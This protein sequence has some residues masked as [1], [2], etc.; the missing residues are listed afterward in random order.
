[1]TTEALL[2][3]LNAGRILE[4]GT[5]ESMGM[6]DISVRAREICALINQGSSDVPRI[7]ELFS[8]LIGEPVPE[9]FRLFPPFTS[10]FGRNI[11]LGEN[12]FINSGC[13][14]QDQGGVWIGSGSLIGHNVVIATLNHDLDPN[15]RQAMYSKPVVLGE[16]VWVGAGAIIL[17]GIT[18]GDGAV[19]GAGSIVTRNVEAC[20]IVAGNPARHIRHVAETP[21]DAALKTVNGGS[22]ETAQSS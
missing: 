12:V 1:M 2:D 7:G 8:E 14:F 16:N 3:L 18:V 9:G 20:S 15:N 11:H 4:P 5:P 10:D 13:R 22:A 17:P 6:N 19:I 21:K